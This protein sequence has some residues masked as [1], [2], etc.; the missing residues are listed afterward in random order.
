[1]P[2][3]L[4]GGELSIQTVYTAM[5]IMNIYRFPME[6]L[7]LARTLWEEAS[8]SF[9]RVRAFLL[10]PEV[11]CVDV[12]GGIGVGIGADDDT[13]DDNNVDGGVSIEES[14][15]LPLGDTAHPKEL[16]VHIDNASFAYGTA[17]NTRKNDNADRKNSY[18]SYASVSAQST[19]DNGIELPAASDLV[20]SESLSASPIALA[21]VS[22][23]IC[24]GELVAI[25][26]SVGSGKTS[27][28]SAMLEQMECVKGSQYLH[29]EVAYVS[30]EHWIQNKSLR[31]N[32]LFYTPFNEEKYI[33]A[34]DASQ[35][36]NDLIMLPSADFTVIGERGINLSGGQKARVNIARSLYAKDDVD[37]VIFDDPLAAVDAHVGKAIFEEAILHTLHDKARVVVFSS[38]YHLLPHFDKIIVVGN[39]RHEGGGSGDG[40]ESSGSDEESDC[41]SIST[42]ISYE[43]LIEE[44]PQYAC[45]ITTKDV[46]ESQD[47]S[48]T[49]SSDSGLRNCQNASMTADDEDKSNDTK[50][51]EGVDEASKGKED[52]S[53]VPRE[54]MFLKMASS[55]QEKQEEGQ[56][57]DLISSE[58]REHGSVS[59]N[60]I[61]KYYSA[62]I[63]GKNGAF[64]L[65]VVL[66]LFSGV[67][68]IRVTGDLWIGLWAKHEEEDSGR[69]PLFYLMVLTAFLFAIIFFTF[70]RSYYFLYACVG[71]SA[72]LHNSMLE[73]IL[74]ASVNKYFDITP[75]GRI[76]NR[77]TKDMDAIDSLLP[78]FL[79]QSIQGGF[80]VLSILI[81]CLASTPFFFVAFVP[82]LVLFY[83][84]Q[85][86]FR[87]T[88]REL[89]RLDGV[90]RSPIYNHLAE[91]LNGLSTIRAFGKQN[92]FLKIHHH[93]SNDNKRCFFAFNIC[94]RWL[95]L[96][97]DVIS[98]FV[99]L[100][101]SL[102]AV[103]MVDMGSSVD[104]NV[105]G[106]AI[107]YSIQLL[108]TLQ[109]TAR[110]IIE[111][112]NNLTS[113]ERLLAFNDI[114]KE[115]TAPAVSTASNEVPSTW[116]SQGSVRISDL[117]LR[118]RD[119]LP[120]VLKKVSLEVPGGCKLGICGRTGSGK[121]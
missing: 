62:A 35:L 98:S 37:L 107:V 11:P 6:V 27:L 93:L 65:L 51:P 50:Q 9:E 3:S 24:R 74:S 104:E 117:S 22:L 43:A 73:S 113:V 86:H 88:S 68:V 70:C 60:T 75:I 97:L 85:K 5:A 105:L 57:A 109:W 17:S 28:L 96:R 30:Q 71:A 114:E 13:N 1:V 40:R 31:E 39:R 25:V 33:E 61:T 84:I 47:D 46:Q 83:L 91:T 112:E 90:S 101:V 116:P 20:E 44:Y 119:G 42:F 36:T 110:V 106:L 89:K 8:K 53:T 76:L 34:I 54:S 67:Q 95:S 49:Q 78:D 38:N 103:L 15:R 80:H 72:N 121:R 48:C 87:M 26:G 64:T 23:S 7:P 77:F 14:G 12:S 69:S 10:L 56:A 16:L 4:L 32:V 92:I 21:N 52:S 111:T 45:A 79:L 120:L 58:D 2:F 102:I 66:F 29:S 100:L 59:I 118:Y 18:D 108:D 55:I 82:I 19:D 115:A 81:L 63:K 99:V 41:S 94:N